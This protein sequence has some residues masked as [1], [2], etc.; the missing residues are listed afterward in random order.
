MSEF[1]E[2]LKGCKLHEKIFLILYVAFILLATALC[3]WVLITGSA[4]WY[5]RAFML[6]VLMLEAFVVGMVVMYD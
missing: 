6:I 1:V 5:L 4:V 2:V 3:V